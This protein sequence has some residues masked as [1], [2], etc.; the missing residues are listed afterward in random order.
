VAD[1]LEDDA[2]VMS[3]TQLG[4][5]LTGQPEEIQDGGVRETVPPGVGPWV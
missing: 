1:A 5:L 2:E 4:E 3:N